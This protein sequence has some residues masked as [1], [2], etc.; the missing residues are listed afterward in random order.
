MQYFGKLIAMAFVVGLSMGALG[1]WHTARVVPKSSEQ[2]SY[3]RLCRDSR[4]L[5]DRRACHANDPKRTQLA[6][7]LAE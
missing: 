2:A 4:G 1:A 3:V 5:L 6:L 7:N